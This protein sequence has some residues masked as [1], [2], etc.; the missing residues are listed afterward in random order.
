MNDANMVQPDGSSFNKTKRSILVVEDDWNSQKYYEYMLSADYDVFTASTAGSAFSMLQEFTFDL[1]L[2]DIMLIGEEDGLSL[3][4]KIRSV[5]KLHLIPVI[6]VSA[7][8]FPAD[9]KKALEAGCNDFLSKP[10]KK[11]DLTFMIN[12][13]LLK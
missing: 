10:V 13:Y 7:Y 5:D 12:K 3:T 6:A 8:A 1:V 2:M 9:K 4:R 11:E